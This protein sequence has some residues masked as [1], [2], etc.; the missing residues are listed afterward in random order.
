MTCNDCPNQ[1]NGTCCHRAIGSDYDKRV[2]DD[3]DRHAQ[4]MSK[5]REFWNAIFKIHDEQV[6]KANQDQERRKNEKRA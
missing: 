4:M 1:T 5:R 6:D 3:A 2:N